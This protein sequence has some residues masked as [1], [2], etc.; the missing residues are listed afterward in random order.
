[1][2][3]DLTVILEDRPGTLADMGQALGNAGINIDGW[4]GFPCEGRGV[5]HIL[6]ED[7]A[8]ARSALE[9]GGMQVDGERDVLV[10][11]IEDRPGAFG[12]IAR[13]IADAGVNF[14]LGYLATNTRLVIGADELEKAQAAL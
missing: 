12:D 5:I 8:G 10:L 11:D 13:K 3:K 1:M 4:C 2:A 9:E 14:N 6:V 7:A